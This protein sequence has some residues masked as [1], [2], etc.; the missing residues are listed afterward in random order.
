MVARIRSSADRDA[1]IFGDEGNDV[2][3][4]GGGNDSLSGEQGN[5]VLAGGTGNDILHGGAGNDQLI[6]GLGTDQLFGRRGHGS[7]HRNGVS[8]SDRTGNESLTSSH[9]TGAVGGLLPP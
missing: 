3:E 6:G 8:Q 4:G 1:T 9:Q 5:D 7:F 2:L